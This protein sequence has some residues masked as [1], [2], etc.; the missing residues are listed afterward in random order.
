MYPGCAR[1]GNVMR[2]VTAD[3]TM[4]GVSVIALSLALTAPAAAQTS[5]G[6]DEG[7]TAEQ[8]ANEGDAIV[9]T[10]Q[11]ASDRA[12]LL[13]K[14]DSDVTSEVVSAND[15]GKLPDQNVAEAVR[16]LSGVTV[17]TDKGEGRYLLI[18]GIEPDL[19][20]VTINN[21]TASAPEPESRN[22]KLDDIPC[23]LIGSATVIKTL[24]PDL[25]ANAIAGQVDIE[26]VSAF[27][28]KKRIFGSARGVGSFYEDTDRTGK[29]GDAS[30]GGLF[31]P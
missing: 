19:A 27:D 24:T 18:R 14:R 11:R 4:L 10:G 8:A 26:T 1:R 17:A 7:Q 20:N 21:Q 25:D 30:I 23:G 16:R 9:V 13:K 31:G 6:T 28:K 2:N 15:V 12:S 3:P 29:E 22:V 5:P